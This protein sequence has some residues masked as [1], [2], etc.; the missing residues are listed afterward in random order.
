MSGHE[1]S[2]MKYEYLILQDELG[3]THTINRA[4]IIVTL[5]IHAIVPFQD[6]KTKFTRKDA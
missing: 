2:A 6:L 3:G 1:S 5:L 4:K